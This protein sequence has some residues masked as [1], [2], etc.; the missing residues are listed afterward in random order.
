MSD[1]DVFASAPGRRLPTPISRRSLIVAAQHSA[2]ARRWRLRRIEDAGLET[3]EISAAE[4]ATIDGRSWDKPFVGGTT[5]DAVHRSVLLRFPAMAEMITAA[6]RK[7]NTIVRADLT[8]T[9]DGYELIPTGYVTVKWRERRGRRIRRPGMSR[10]GPCASPGSLIWR[11]VRPSMPTS[12]AGG[13]GRGTARLTPRPIDTLT[14]W[15]R[16]SCR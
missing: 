7:G 11:R 3:V 4:T 1:D 13:F 5:V 8:I 15:S 9:Y 10:R 16:K 6:L 2:P 12:M 14:Y